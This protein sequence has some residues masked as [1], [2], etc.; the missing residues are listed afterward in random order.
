MCIFH[1]FFIFVICCI[2][3]GTFISYLCYI[4]P[5]MPILA[6]EYPMSLTRQNRK[7]TQNLL[8]TTRGHP[9]VAETMF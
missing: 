3:S 6:Y 5:K 1:A 2:L 4:F 9:R 7:Y 8:F